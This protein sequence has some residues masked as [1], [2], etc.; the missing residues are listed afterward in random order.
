MSQKIAL[1]IDHVTIAGST[2]ARLEQ[3][4]A[5]VGLVTDYGGPH[6]NGVTHM[7]LLGF[8]DGSYIEL[9]STMEAGRKDTDFWG[10]HIVQDGGPC[11]WAVYVEDVAA[12]AARVAQQGVT[13]SGPHY[14]N[15]S[16]PD[17]QL[18]EWELAFLGEQVQVEG[19]DGPPV[20]GQVLGLEQDGS[21]RLQNG[22]DKTVA[23][24]FGDVRLRPLA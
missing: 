10:E 24:R 22:Y 19:G 4:F 6:S 23:V 7:A 18:V 13:V 8:D 16:R 15:R 5:N 21:L 11:A 14:M 9:I 1:K 12:E 2:L 17:G 20:V 3:A